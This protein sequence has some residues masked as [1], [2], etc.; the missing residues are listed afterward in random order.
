MHIPLI[1]G[2]R[3]IYLMDVFH[4]YR[5]LVIPVDRP[6]ASAVKLALDL[7]SHRHHHQIWLSKW[8]CKLNCFVSWC[9]GSRIRHTSSSVEDVMSNQRVTRNSLVPN[10][11]CSAGLMNHWT[12]M[13]GS[14]LLSPSLP[15]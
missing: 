11:R 3:I 10:L 8:P 5:W 1:L 15:C 6:K 4:N 13:L 2:A 7:S 14:V 9:K 12:S